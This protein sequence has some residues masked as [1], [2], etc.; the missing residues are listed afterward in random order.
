MEVIKKYP[1]TMDP[2]TA[3]KL[4]KSPDVKRMSDAED[5][6][7]EVKSWIRYTEPDQKT[8]EL[9]EILTIETI[10]NEMFGTVS[11]VFKKEFDDIVS[12]FGDDV[13]AIKVISGTS[14]AGRKFIT[15]TVE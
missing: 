5:A 7:L 11:E 1:E 9:R 15:C 2:R 6:I 12:F 4:M 3:Y 14:R 8:G 10:D 13:G